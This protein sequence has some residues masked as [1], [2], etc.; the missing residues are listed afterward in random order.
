MIDN[1]YLKDGINGVKFAHEEVEM[2][3]RDEEMKRKEKS[4]TSSPHHLHSHMMS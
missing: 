1:G 3:V 2:E 4:S